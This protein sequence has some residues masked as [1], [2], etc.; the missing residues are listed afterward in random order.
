MACAF[1]A[2]FAKF[3]HVM[4]FFEKKFEKARSV[5]MSTAIHVYGYRRYLYSINAPFRRIPPI[6]LLDSQKKQEDK[7]VRRFLQLEVTFC[8][9]KCRFVWAL[10]GYAMSVAQ[11][12][13]FVAQKCKNFFAYADFLV[14][15]V[16]LRAKILQNLHFAQF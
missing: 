16:P 10:R 7:G 4:Q 8:R 3:L 2:S 11:K 6:K 1:L 5:T 13:S 15:S 14:A 12:M 9:K